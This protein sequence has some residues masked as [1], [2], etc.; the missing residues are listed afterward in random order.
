V[1]GNLDRIAAAPTPEAIHQFRVGLRRLRSALGLFRDCLDPDGR[2][3]LAAGLKDVAGRFGGARDLDVFAA[4]TLAPLRAALDGTVDLAAAE[5]AVAAAREAARGDLAH[6]V[7]S[8][9]S[10]TRCST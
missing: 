3:A 6:A 1:L 9:R 4:E 5:A 2:A 10:P 7:W 8:P